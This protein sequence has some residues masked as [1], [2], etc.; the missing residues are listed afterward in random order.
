MRAHSH[1]LNSHGQPPDSP[2]H[3]CDTPVPPSHQHSHITSVVHKCVM[4]VLQL[5][6][7][8]T[9]ETPQRNMATAMAEEH[10][11]TTPT[12]LPIGADTPQPHRCAR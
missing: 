3:Q 10:T 12:T 8:M 2:H 4:Q 9:Q 1:V 6:H 11:S 5:A 7:A